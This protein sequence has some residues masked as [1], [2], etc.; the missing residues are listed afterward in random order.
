MSKDKTVRLLF[1]MAM[2]FLFTIS[3]AQFLKRDSLQNIEVEAIRKLYIKDYPDKFYIKPILT[4]RSLN[5]EFAD[6][7]KAAKKLTYRP[8]SSNYFGFGLYAFDI[9][10]EVNLKLPQ[11]EKDTPPTIYG[12]T[13]SFDFQTNIYTK[14]WG[15]DIAFQRYSELYLDKPSSHFSNW[16]SGDPYPQRPDLSLRNFQMNVFYIFNNDKF[17][18]RSAYN[19]ADRQIKSS[20]S[21]LLSTFVSTYSYKSDSTLIP[22]SAKPAYLENSDMQNGRITT[23]AF[24][25]GYT[26]NFIY[27]KFYFNGSISIGPGHLWI[28]YNENDREKEDILIR[29]VY[30][31][32][33]ALGFNGDWFFGGITLVNK[34]ISAKINNMEINSASGNFKF[35]VGFRIDEFGILKEK[36]L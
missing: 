19:Q 14:K 7:N 21:F 8:S 6:A 18:Y 34:I 16:Q 12:E 29:P 24:L 9:G 33:A 30:N 5:L 23:L 10:I 25:P 35:F 22:D 15:A 1:L 3:K 36:L 27:R 13:K 31:F 17:S 4:V 20:G 32:R 11:N 2:V 26:H 28:K